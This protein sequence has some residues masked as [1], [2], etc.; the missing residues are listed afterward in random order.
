MTKCRYRATCMVVG[1]LLSI[2]SSLLAVGPAEA[3]RRGRRV[4]AAPTEA[5]P[6]PV[7]WEQP[8]RIRELDFVG[9]P[10]G[11]TGAPKPPFKFV[12]EDTGGSN[13]KIEVT[14]ASGRTWG[15]KWGSEVNAETFATRIAWAAGYFVEPAYFVPNGRIVGV[16]RGTL[17]R[18]KKYVAD[19]GSFSDARFEL[20]EKFLKKLKDEQGWAWNQNPF[21]GS[22]ELNGLKMIVMLT[23]NWDSKDV[24]DVSR[25]SNTAIYLTETQR[26]VEARYLITDWGGSMGKWGNYFTREK[27][28][29]E[30]FA[31]QTPDFIKGVDG[32]FVKWGYSG[33]RTDDVTRGI[34]VADVQWFVRIVGR[35]TDDQL[36]SGLRA[37]GATPQEA[38]IFTRSLRERIRQMQ[39]VK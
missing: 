8:R 18:A 10:G 36:R 19:D 35:V 29:A 16:E 2:T 12:E 30:A 6:L 1:V 25:G 5:N 15:V 13:P 32:G 9:G 7:I 39:N 21:V 3:Q 33:Q 23:S 38:D 24:R 22:K 34:P 4:T 26:G 27:W 31:K 28:D 37:S 17:D 14:D 11:R 20:K